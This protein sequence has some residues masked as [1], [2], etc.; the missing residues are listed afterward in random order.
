MAL[1]G[2]RAP[3]MQ[4]APEN[5][6]VRAVESAIR[7]YAAALEAGNAAEAR[8]IFPAMSDAEHAHFAN[9][10]ASGGRVSTKWKVS[11]VV[12]TGDS[13]TVR[14][15]GRTRAAPATGTATDEKLD[16]RAVV[17]RS[18]GAWRLRTFGAPELR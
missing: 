9:L 5:P 11:D 3:A 8:R 12:I 15:R 14:V 10:F 13:A 4:A 2:I 6:D 16:V 1:L 17:E 18:S 7:S